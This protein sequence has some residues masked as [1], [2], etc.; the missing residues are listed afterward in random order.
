MR[1]VAAAV[2]KDGS[3]D[4]LFFFKVQSPATGISPRK[5]RKKKGKKSPTLPYSG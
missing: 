3:L 2:E 1:W 5:K 4:L